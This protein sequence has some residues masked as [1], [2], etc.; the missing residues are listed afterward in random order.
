MSL[1]AS[2][3]SS[4]PA[5]SRGRFLSWVVEA[6]RLWRRAPLRLIGL[7]LVPVLVEIPLQLIP[8]VGIVL[9]KIAVCMIGAGLFLG[10]D[11]LARGERLRAGCL[12][13]GLRGP[14][15]RPVA[16][17]SLWALT[18]TATQLLVAALVYGGAAALDVLLGHRTALMAGPAFR[19]VLFLPGVVPGTLLMLAMPAVVL[20]GVPPRRAVKLSVQQV[21]AFPA[22]FGTFML[23][24]MGFI[25]LMVV[26]GGLFLLVP[27][28]VLAAGTLVVNY[29]AY[30]DVLRVQ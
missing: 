1:S 8:G 10:V 3:L 30:R 27:F 18:I 12:L 23:I 24:S 4:A 19:L 11:A 15:R 25:A 22:A 9:S 2:S 26:T 21:L 29:V 28:M 6:L 20:D 13:A 16:V 17:L 5:L 14:R 7:S